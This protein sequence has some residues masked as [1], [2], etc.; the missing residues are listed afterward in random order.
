M[1]WNIGKLVTAWI[2]AASNSWHQLTSFSV[3]KKPT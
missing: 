3:N 1:V 2:S